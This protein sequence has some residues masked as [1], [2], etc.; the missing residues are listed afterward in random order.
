MDAL[1]IIIPI[2]FILFVFY[3]LK[4]IKR[5]LLLTAIVTMPLRT[6]YTLFGGGAHVGWSSGIMISISDVS[7]L[8]LFLYLVLI[9]KDDKFNTPSRIIIPTLFFILA[10]VISVLNSTAGMSTFYQVFMVFQIAFLYYFVLVNGIETEKELR[11]VVLFLTIS[12]FIQGAHGTLQFFTGEELEFFKTGHHISEFDHY[13]VGETTGFRRIYGSVGKPN[14][15]AAYL[16]PLIILN[17]SLLMGFNHFNK[18]RLLAVVFGI[19]SLLLSFSRGGLISFGV[20]FFILLLLINKDRIIKFKNVKMVL[21]IVI[22]I[23]IPFFSALTTR[24]S[25]FGDNAAMSRIPLMKVALNMILEHPIIGVG[26]NTFR[27][28]IRSYTNSP[29]LQGI[30]LHEVHNLYLLVFAESGV[31]GI[32]AFLWLL[33]SFFKEASPCTKQKQNSYIYQLGLGI[34]LGFVA[35]AIHMMVDIYNSYL[36]LSNLFVLASVLTASKKVIKNNAPTC[37]AS[38]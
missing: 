22:I 24:L 33:F 6:S 27:N 25:G 28:V 1:K 15:F 30:Y 32:I 7:L 4:D 38:I 36:L 31:V 29:E 19:M 20:A 11:Y 13:S 14:G 5:F 34:Q 35:A 18:V 16:V 23:A 9:K 8:L 10:C 37:F 26:A 21:L 12:L 17:L 3:G 2:Y